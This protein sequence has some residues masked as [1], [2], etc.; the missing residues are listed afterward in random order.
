MKI[1]LIITGLTD[2]KDSYR[3]IS[4]YDIA[5]K[6]YLRPLLK[7]SRIDSNFVNQASKEIK[8]FNKVTFEVDSFFNNPTAPHLEDFYVKYNLISSEDVFNEN[9]IR[10]FLEKIADNNIKDVYGEY[11][12][13]YKDHYVIPEGVGKRS[14]GTIICRDVRVYED[15]KGKTRV[16]YTDKTGYELKNIPCVAHDKQY[17]KKGRYKNIALRLGLSRLYDPWSEK[18]GDNEAFYWPQVSAVFSEWEI[19]NE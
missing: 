12:E 1:E 7:N 13:F 4:G 11:I 6:R 17:K 16:D 14:L 18:T 9:D 10:S 5:N 3:C 2:M 8:I 19:S 15:G